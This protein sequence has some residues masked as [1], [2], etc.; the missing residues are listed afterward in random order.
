[1]PSIVEAGSGS[2]DQYDKRIIV[3]PVRM[4]TLPR[5]RRMTTRVA[6]PLVA[7]V[8]HTQ[9]TTYS[10]LPLMPQSSCPSP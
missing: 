7:L 1:M 8:A 9:H 4:R 5:T 10:V 2:Y 3:W 6:V